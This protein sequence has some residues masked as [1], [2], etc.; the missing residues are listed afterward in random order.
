MPTKTI[1]VIEEV[2]RELLRHKKSGESFSD[3][4]HRLVHKKGKI[5]ECAGLWS[6]MNP[7]DVASVNKAIEKRRRLSA[8]ARKK[9]L[10]LVR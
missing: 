10:K 2:Y 8:S 9:K 5:T 3:E 1:S 7:S 6:W 4:L